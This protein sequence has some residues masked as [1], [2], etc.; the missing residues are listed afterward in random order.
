M[1][2]V[3]P[4]TA[5]MTFHIEDVTTC[6]AH[7]TAHT[8]SLTAHNN[9]ATVQI[10]D[11]TAHTAPVTTHLE[12]VTSHTTSVTAYTAPGTMRP[13]FE[14][15]ATSHEKMLKPFLNSLFGT[16]V[17]CARNSGNFFLLFHFFSKVESG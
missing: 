4:P 11:V 16:W 8:A 17:N 15:T 1:A 9:F 7:V 3:M 5:T 6:T 12:A 10:E 14:P 13:H 2:T